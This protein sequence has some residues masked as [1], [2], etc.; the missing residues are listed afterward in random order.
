[1][2]SVEEEQELAGANLDE[3]GHS[4]VQPKKRLTVAG[5]QSQIET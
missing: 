5:L 1:M 3:S 2:D 4:Q